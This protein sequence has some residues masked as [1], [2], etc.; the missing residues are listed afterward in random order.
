MAKPGFP[1]HRSLKDAKEL[2]LI[3]LSVVCL[4]ASGHSEESREEA[5]SRV[6]RCSTSLENTC[7]KQQHLKLD[8]GFPTGDRR[9]S[10]P[11]VI[12]VLTVLERLSYAQTHGS[13]FPETRGSGIVKWKSMSMS[14]GSLFITEIM[15]K[16]LLLTKGNRKLYKTIHNLNLNKLK[17]YEYHK[18]LIF[19]ERGKNINLLL[20]N[21]LV[22]HLL[23]WISQRKSNQFV[24]L[25][26]YHQIILRYH[27]EGNWIK[28][29]ILDDIQT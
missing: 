13:A 2:S 3:A 10:S 28:F 9:R 6:G 14:Q 27:S 4:P 17:I 5:R 1:G 19:R 22:F 12:Y 20:K 21:I 26:V 23:W 16:Q 25:H 24:L 29:L 11:D 7:K 8:I 15:N 18:H